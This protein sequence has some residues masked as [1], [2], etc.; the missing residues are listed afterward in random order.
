[1]KHVFGGK[2][3]TQS[4]LVRNEGMKSEAWL[5]LVGISAGR[6]L[7]VSAAQTKDAKLWREG[8]NTWLTRCANPQEKHE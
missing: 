3:G 8:R 6:G 7:S 5:F 2:E 1:M 4:V